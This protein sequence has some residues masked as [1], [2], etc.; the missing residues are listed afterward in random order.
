MEDEVIVNV[1]PRDKHWE[2]VFDGAILTVYLTKMARMEQTNNFAT[3]DVD[4]QNVEQ[5]YKWIEVDDVEGSQHVPWNGR[6]DFVFFRQKRVQ[7]YDGVEYHSID[8][9][10][11]RHS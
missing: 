10:I 8:A 1:L 7:K 11:C 2:G 3:I 5:I 6:V 9:H 4:V